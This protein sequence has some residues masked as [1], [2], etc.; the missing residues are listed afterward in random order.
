MRRRV[1]KNYFNKGYAREYNKQTKTLSNDLFKFRYGN[2]QKGEFTGNQL[3]AGWLSTGTSKVI[4]TDSQYLKDNIDKLRGWKFYEDKQIEE[5]L[6]TQINVSL[7]QGAY[8]P[9]FGTP[10]AGNPTDVRTTDYVTVV[11]GAKYQFNLVGIEKTD[12]TVN[13][14]QFDSND[15]TTT[16]VSVLNYNESLILENDTVKVKI[17]AEETFL[18]S[19]NTTIIT[20][21]RVA[22]QERQFK[23]KSEITNVTLATD[24]E[25]QIGAIRQRK[26]RDV[27]VI[28]VS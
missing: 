19:S 1:N 27:L 13:V 26:N 22:Q 2:V 14:L 24:D 7:E 15:N 20:T 21:Y 4:K 28:E 6:I 23:G 18:D 12:K 5:L 16:V 3:I 11:S 8:D 9:I 10:L 25:Q 17:W